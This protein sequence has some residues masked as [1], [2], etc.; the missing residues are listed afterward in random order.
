MPAYNACRDF[1]DFGPW[2]FSSTAEDGRH[3]K[4]D[5]RLFVGLCFRLLS[6]LG[7]Q[8]PDIDYDCVEAAIEAIREPQ[9]YAILITGLRSINAH[10]D[11]TNE[12][13]ACCAAQ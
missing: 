13:N 4:N 6:L 10:T 12:A 11:L 1:P 9:H 8:L 2:A 7:C 5:L 3:K